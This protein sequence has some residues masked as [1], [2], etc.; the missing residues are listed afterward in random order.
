[1]AQYFIRH[2]LQAVVL[3]VLLTLFG[4]VAAF[5]LPVA[6]Y[7]SIMP[8]TVSVSATYQ[9][10]DAQT[11]QDTVATIIEGEI[12]GLDGLRSMTSNS[13]ASGEYQLSIEFAPG[14]DGEIAAA[15]VQNRIATVMPSLPQTVQNH[16]VTTSRSLPGMV[17]AMSL[18]SPHGT[19]DSIFLQNYAKTYFLDKIKRVSGVGS[20]DE[21]AEDYAMRIWLQ[22]DKLAAKK[23]A[24]NDVL[25]AVQ[26]QNAQPAAGTLGKMPVAGQ[27]E[28][29]LTG[30]VMNRRETPADFGQIILPA[31]KSSEIVRLQDVA[32]VAEGKKDTRYASYQDGLE[33]A[34]FSISLTDSANALETISEV[35]KILAEAQ[36][37]FPP[38][39]EY[40]IVVDQTSFIEESMAEVAY[41]FGEALLLVALIVYLFLG[42]GRATLITL[43]AVPVSLIATFFF[44]YLCGYS[45]NLLTLFAMILAIGLVV[46]DAIVIIESVS[47]H[48]ERGLPVKEAASAAMAEVQAPILAIAFVLAAVFVP[49]AFLPG[50]TG[51]LYRQ[52]ALTLVVSMGLSAFAA[53]SLTPA[54]CVLLLRSKEQLAEKNWL[55]AHF[56]RCLAWV[57]RKYQRIL[58]VCL[59]RGRLALLMLVLLTAG[60]V[61]LYLL[62][63]REFLPEEDQGYIMAG[64]KL[65]AGTSLNHTI[66]S[67]LQLSEKLQAHE[68]VKAVISI[69]GVDLMADNTRSD[70]G[71]LFVALKDWS[72][73]LADGQGVDDLLNWLDETAPQIVPEAVVLSINPPAIPEM[74]MTGGANLQLQDVSGHSEEELWAV[75]NKITALAKER[76][77]IDEVE[78]DFSIGTPYADFT[79]DEDKAK[80]MGVNMSDVYSALQVNFGGE[81]VNDFVRYGNVYK[82]IVQAD[83][84]F[85]D[86]LADMR[87]LFV[88]NSD[89]VMV[90]LDT[91][92]KAERSSGPASISRYDGVRSIH[93]EISAGEG[94]SSGQAMDAMQEVVQE[95]ASHGF[96]M[97]WAGSSRHAKEA[98]E[99]TALL[100]LLSL[101]FVFLCLTF[102]YESWRLPWAVLLSVPVGI[103]GAL[104]S[105]L[106]A[107]QPG[108]IYMQIGI[109]LVVALAAKNA[110]LI[111]EFAKQRQKKGASV[112]RAAVMATKLRLRPILMTSVAF[113]AG[114]LPLALASGAGSGARSNMGIAVVGGMTLATLLGVL[115]VPVLY[116]A[117]AGKGKKF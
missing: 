43:L 55:L 35:K 6:E 39:M 107:Q 94:Y 77:E 75:V 14:V 53:L 52:F 65:P 58:G 10:A 117:V 63:P 4:L 40:R 8:P 88:R 18:C 78:A 69:G 100:L 116:M 98:Q 57:G 47:R 12:R 84:T 74:G 44:F 109:L 32:S 19:Y 24:V 46:D 5:R 68:A 48:L 61:G 64:L 36:E 20:V 9:G 26:E 21:Y 101:V 114:C 85:R 108:S 99:E 105:E 111:V 2:P 90:P 3:A 11:V 59:R 96:H 66:D 25:S 93:F 113:I 80:L 50:M 7:P 27:Q 41:T 38:D 70:S 97:A 72:E 22:P 15:S 115:I 103:G 79:V 33:A 106:I 67:M 30:R 60:T 62:L 49:V 23:L 87:F 16:G 92:V 81:E 110:I 54:L 83:K 28:H 86:D 1:M 13:D 34:S 89:G 31:Q 82:V 91:L 104:L 102:I 112:I 73:R 51:T 76:P 42:N 45:L 95:A 37:M 29:Q 17:F 71:I 56:A